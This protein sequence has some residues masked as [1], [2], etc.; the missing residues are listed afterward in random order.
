MVLSGENLSV[1]ADRYNCTVSD[2]KR[3]NRL[4]SNNLAIGKRLL[5]R[6]PEHTKASSVAS[7]GKSSTKQSG[8]TKYGYH[9]VEAGDTLWEIARRYEGMTVEQLKQI[10]SLRSNDLKVGTKLKVIRS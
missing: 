3:W 8:D 9:I 1:I 10:N 6:A 7:S 5:V 4:K 2:L